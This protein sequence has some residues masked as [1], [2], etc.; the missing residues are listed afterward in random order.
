M[1][2]SAQVTAKHLSTALT[3]RETVAQK[4]SAPIDF[5]RTSP[6]GEARIRQLTEA[7]RQMR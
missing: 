6:L 2:S 5:D 3:K 1:Q 4:L 7:T